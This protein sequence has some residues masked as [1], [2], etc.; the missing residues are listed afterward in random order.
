MYIGD[1]QTMAAES[2]VLGVPFIRFN[3]FVGKIGYLHELENR[4]ELG[5]GF[6]SNDS[7]KMLS[8][9]S[10]ILS[11]PG[12]NKDWKNKRAKMLSDKINVSSFFSWFIGDYPNSKL[13][14]LKKPDYINNF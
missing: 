5:Y 13:M 3:D 1:S 7:E 4:Y 10:E 12:L 11:Y 14:L 8:K 6:K 2:A 9:V